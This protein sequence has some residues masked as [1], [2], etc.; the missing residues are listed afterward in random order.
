MDNDKSLLI[1]EENDVVNEEKTQK[2]EIDPVELKLAM[3]NKQLKDEFLKEKSS[4]I[5]NDDFDNEIEQSLEEMEKSVGEHFGSEE[6]SSET[7]DEEM[8]KKQ[9]RAVEALL[10][11]RLQD[12]F[13]PFYER[14]RL[15][16]CKEE[17]ESDEEAESSSKPKIVVSPTNDSEILQRNRFMITKT[18][19]VDDYEK[20]PVSILKKTP[21][22]PSPPTNQ[23]SIHNSPKKIR[24]EATEAL[25]NVSSD[26]NS[27]TIH[28]PCSAGVSQRTN[29]TNMFTE[30]FNPHLD[31][32]YFDTSLVEV[33]TSQQ[34]LSTSTKSLDDRGGK[35][36]AEVVND[37]W[38]KRPD[39][40]PQEKKVNLSSESVRGSLKSVSVSFIEK[41]LQIHRHLI[42]VK[43]L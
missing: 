4:E 27:N 1:I 37:I 12:N 6:E 18:K 17:S 26:K 16:Q 10:Q 38:V 42:L 30:L 13:F 31:R 23:R 33:R 7:E 19:D 3:R 15:S 24:Y 14:R 36:V 40:K 43:I 20:Q 2:K 39:Y 25:R 35:E 11:K 28:F 34:A 21:K 8:S 32:R 5:A 9:Y 41:I 29:A 22:T